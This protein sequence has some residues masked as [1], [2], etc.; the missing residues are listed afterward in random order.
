ME[1][2]ELP[3]TKNIVFSFLKALIASTRYFVNSIYLAKKKI[4]IY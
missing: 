1:L 2:Q 3:E 4:F